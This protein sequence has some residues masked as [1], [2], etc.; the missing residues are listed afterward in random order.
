MIKLK[1]HNHT[2]APDSPRGRK[3]R[4]IARLRRE[5]AAERKHTARLERELSDLRR[6]IKANTP[7]ATD[8]PLRRLKQQAAGTHKEERLLD[9]A[10][11]RAHHYRKGSFLRYLWE[12]VRESAPVQVV[13]KLV[14]YLRRVKLIQ[15][16][17]TVLLA[18]GAV[19]A[20]AIVSATI[21]PFLFF[22]TSLLT[23]LALLRS[24]R[25]NRI[26]RHELTDRR[27]RIMIPPRGGSLDR[28]SFF[29]RN[30]RAMAA[31]ENV[32]VIVVTPYLVSC[33]G[34]GGKGRF[35]TARKETDDL[36]LVRKHYFFVLRRK[37]LDILDGEITVVY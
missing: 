18:L 15:T 27:I 17:L 3:D 26:L 5:L 2:P 13:S 10:N 6:D 20:V 19:V 22:G 1:E 16:V 28:G 14:H 11:R 30:A 21:L 35:F 7:A 34:L 37:V 23:M 36:Y 32:T 31:E 8:Q 9:A 4:E 33:R 29:I 12:S 25:M 24:R